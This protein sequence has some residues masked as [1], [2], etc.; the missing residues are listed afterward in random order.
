MPHWSL[1]ARSPAAVETRRYSLKRVLLSFVIITAVLVPSETAVGV[2][3]VK[4]ESELY[5]LIDAH[6]VM[7]SAI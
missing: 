1:A 7:A 3:F 4:L 6:L 2:S 5:A